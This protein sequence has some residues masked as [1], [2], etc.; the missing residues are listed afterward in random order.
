[1]IQVDN[2]IISGYSDDNTDKYEIKNV[3][4]ELG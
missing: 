1:M 3:F 4:S 2:I